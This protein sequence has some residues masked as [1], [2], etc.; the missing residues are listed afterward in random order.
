MSA[1]GKDFRITLTN[2]KSFDVDID[3]AIVPITSNIK[4]KINEVNGD[5]TNK[6]TFSSKPNLATVT[7]GMI[8]SIINRTDGQGRTDRFTITN[9][10]AA[11]GELTVDP[12]PTAGGKF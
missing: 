7:T 8:L 12:T 1:V 4:A 3:E 6:I 10:N 9:V 11:T 5:L 2:G